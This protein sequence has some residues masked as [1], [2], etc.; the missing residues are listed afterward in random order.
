MSFKDSQT[1]K[2]LQT[3]MAGEQKAGG[4]Y[5][6][7]AEI[8][9]NDGY[10][11]IANIFDETANNEREHAEIWNKELHCGDTTSTLANLKEAAAGENYEWTTMYNDFADTAKAEGYGEIARLFTE[12][13]EIES[14][15]EERYNKLASN[16]QNDEVFCKPGAQVWICMVCGHVT[17]GDCAPEVC[18]VCGAPQAF[19]ELKAENY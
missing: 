17:Y 7:Y 15:H 8:A 2:N 4:K 3:A 19:E 5:R 14:Q 12:V 9:R 16:I 11:Q 10:E 18:P 6:M 1:Y 13:G